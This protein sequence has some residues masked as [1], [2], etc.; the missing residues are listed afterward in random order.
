MNDAHGLLMSL[1]WN[2]MIGVKIGEDASAE[3]FLA[4]PS[5]LPEAWTKQMQPS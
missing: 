3:A 4:K 5:L 2:G 1:F